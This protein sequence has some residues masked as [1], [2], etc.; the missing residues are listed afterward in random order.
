MGEK[1]TPFQPWSGVL[2]LKS[3]RFLVFDKGTNGN[4]PK[5]LVFHFTESNFLDHFPRFSY[6]IAVSE[7][8]YQRYTKEV[9]V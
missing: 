2:D 5:F 3:I 1:G 8:G 6:Q 4:L 7:K 9:L